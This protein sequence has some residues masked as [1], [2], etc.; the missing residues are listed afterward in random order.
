MFST[1][2]RSLFRTAMG[3]VRSRRQ[4]R[5]REETA[6]STPYL[7]MPILGG[8]SGS[9]IREISRPERGRALAQPCI[10]RL[11]SPLIGS[12]DTRLASLALGSS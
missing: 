2:P 9:A 11:R 10:G 12:H 4:R 7:D 6:A 8:R 1:R 3:T 5:R